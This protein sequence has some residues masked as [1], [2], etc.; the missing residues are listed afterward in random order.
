MRGAWDEDGGQIRFPPIFLFFPPPSA[1]FSR[2]SSRALG[3]GNGQQKD[4][5][6]GDIGVL[7][8]VILGSDKIDRVGQSSLARLGVILQLPTSGQ[9]GLGL[10][11]RRAPCDTEMTEKRFN[12]GQGPP[13]QWVA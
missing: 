11:R 9:R 7:G 6:R 4:K 12:E 10:K 13:T 2:L 5:V 8:P 1:L 3:W